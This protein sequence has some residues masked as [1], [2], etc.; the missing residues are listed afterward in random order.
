MSWPLHIAHSLLL[1][2]SAS[3]TTFYSRHV[4]NPFFQV[5]K[6]KGMLSIYFWGF[7]IPNTT[8]L[9]SLLLFF[10]PDHRHIDPFPIHVTRFSLWGAALHCNLKL[11]TLVL[12]S[13]DCPVPTITNSKHECFLYTVNAPIHT[14]SEHSQA[15]LG[16][17]RKCLGILWSLSRHCLNNRRRY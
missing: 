1:D 2:S 15:W 4:S 12:Q 14:K 6:L 7:Q 5:R 16:Q 3:A 9:D 10:L 11:S 8:N 13:A 17:K